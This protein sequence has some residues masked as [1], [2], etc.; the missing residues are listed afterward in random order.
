MQAL[1]YKNDAIFPTFK[2]FLMSQMYILWSLYTL[3]TFQ[4][5]QK[6]KIK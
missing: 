4:T 2:M 3:V 5:R 1:W 6:G